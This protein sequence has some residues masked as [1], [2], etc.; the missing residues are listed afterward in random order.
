MSMKFQSWV[1]D[2][3]E[4]A[5]D[6]VQTTADYIHDKI[7]P[8]DQEIRSIKGEKEWQLETLF[9]YQHIAKANPELVN[10][11]KFELQREADCGAWEGSNY[12]DKLDKVIGDC[13][14][15]PDYIDPFKKYPDLEEVMYEFIEKEIQFVN[16]RNLRLKN[17]RDKRNHKRSEKRRYEYGY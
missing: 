6:H 14:S 2:L 10:E 17:R 12:Y 8:D 1:M 13:E 3:Y 4:G 16:C 5:V 11:Y 15:D 9:R 7:V